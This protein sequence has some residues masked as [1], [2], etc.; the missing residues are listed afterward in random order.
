MIETITGKHPLAPYLVLYNKE[1]NKPILDPCFIEYTIKFTCGH[2]RST[3]KNTYEMADQYC[4]ECTAMRE[5]RQF[6][7]TGVA[8][9]EIDH[10]RDYDIQIK[11]KEWDPKAKVGKYQIMRPKKMANGKYIAHTDFTAM[12]NYGTFT[13]E[14]IEAKQEKTAEPASAVYKDNKALTV[15][16]IPDYALYSPEVVKSLREYLTIA[17]VKAYKVIPRD[18]KGDGT[19]NYSREEELDK[20]YPI[21]EPRTVK[22]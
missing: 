14:E 5:V 16:E 9:E 3:F 21:P 12:Q 6:L 17:D 8:P 15:F 19:F 22:V 10:S 18:R 4:D 11:L 1:T 20:N 13:E 7:F 2:E